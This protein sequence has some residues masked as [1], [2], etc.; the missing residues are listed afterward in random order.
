M[1]Q[2]RLALFSLVWFVALGG[3]ASSQND[4]EV[5][6]QIWPESE[7]PVGL[8]PKIESRI[9]KLISQ[10]T[11]RQKVGQ[12]IQADIGSIQPDDLKTYPLGSVLNGGNSAPGGDNRADAQAWLDLAD[13][14]YQASQQC[15]LQGGP[16]IPLMWGTD[17]VHGHN[18]IVGATFFPH[19]IGLGATRNPKLLREIGAVTAKEIRVTG[20]EWTFAPTIAVVRDDRWGRTYEG[21]SEDPAVTASYTGELIEGIQ[22][23]AGQDDF[24]T[25][26][27]VIATAKHFVGDGGTF[28]GKDQGDNQM[29]EED[30]RD[31]QAA[32]YPVAINA[33]VQCVMA[34]FSSWQG[35]KIHGHRG[36]LTDVL[37]GR[38]G[39]DGFI[40]G[41]W[42][43]HGQVPGC[44][45]T[46][47]LP[48]L[49]AGLDMFMAPDS[50]KGMF[51]SLMQHAEA[52]EVDMARLDDAVR[53]ILRVKL[54]AKLFDAGLPST[55][56]F[57][58]DFDQL[59]TPEHRDVARRA[60]RQSLVL[61]K[62]NKQTLPLSPSSTILVA[63]DGADNIGKQCGGWSLSWQGTGNSN[64]DFP[65]GTS[66]YDGLKAQMNAAG[67]D[68]ILASEAAPRIKPDAVLVV[69]GE[70]PYAEFQG[71]VETLA[72]KPE[73]RSDLQLLQQ[74]H[75]QGIPTVGVFL[76]GRPLWVNAEI[77][78]TDAF[79]AAWLP[80]SEGVGVA[81]VLL[82]KTDG[83][84]QYD[85]QGKLPYSWPRT[86]DQTPLNVGDEDYDPLFA[87]GYGLTYGDQ[88]TVG[89]LAESYDAQ[90]LAGR[91][92]FFQSGRAVAPWQMTLAADDETVAVR[93]TRAATTGGTLQIYSADEKA[94]E[95]IRVVR[96]N[97][98]RP[99]AFAFTSPTPV[100]LAS[101]QKSIRIRLRVDQ[102]AS[103]DVTLRLS[104]SDSSATVSITDRIAAAGQGQW[105]SLTVPLTSFSNSDAALSG[106]SGIEIATDGS[107][108]ISVSDIDLQ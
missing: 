88:V 82:A 19:N 12:V 94:Q 48:V 75:D 66:I 108:Q 90:N 59:G 28:G 56:P 80:G 22:G 33:G 35:K 99:A 72:Y 23:V 92:R 69:F 16:Y 14:F 91:S 7:S 44:T 43:A 39:F 49:N 15:D 21:Y 46:D 55:R 45:V 100:E 73:D 32:G 87:Y 27:H 60:V 38:M 47:A 17:A 85:F 62:N 77:N 34:S 54:R 97:G 1:F 11:L 71:D 18:N 98:A 68:A 41:D 40:V 81:D 53:R 65:G 105:V 64:D 9:T 10:M 25:G 78:A 67:G 107:L 52:G 106:C 74:Y 101:D 57:A 103:E 42:N 4:G 20:Q 5:H 8:D 30:L 76:S 93:A 24:L 50:W 63:G 6:P 79:V 89:E 31:L 2:S 70:D 102:P 3:V 37:K 83:T 86:P 96:W 36:L 95:D 26:A 29:S 13:A 104:A 84:P 51:D 61:L 58:G